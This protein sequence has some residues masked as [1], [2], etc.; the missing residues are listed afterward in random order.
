[1]SKKRKKNSDYHY[2]ERRDNAERIQAQKAAQKKTG[3]KEKILYLCAFLCLMVALVL[4]ILSRKNGMGETLSPLY[5][6]ISGVGL[7]LLGRSY[8]R[9]RPKAARVCMIIG[10]VAL[11]LSAFIFFVNTGV[12]S[13]S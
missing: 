6:T 10:V 2:A 8:D 3:R 11:L 9:E 12:L 7:L 4:W 1:M 13:F 5:G